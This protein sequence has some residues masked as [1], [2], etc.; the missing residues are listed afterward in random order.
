M[1]EREEFDGVDGEVGGGT[2]RRV[3]RCIV[4]RCIRRRGIMSVRGGGAGMGLA[5]WLGGG[6]LVGG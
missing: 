4:G 5:G 6:R 2:P 1:E 3:R